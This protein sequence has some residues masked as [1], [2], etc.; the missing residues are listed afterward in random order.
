MHAFVHGLHYGSRMHIIET[1]TERT[2]L[3]LVVMPIVVDAMVQPF[4]DNLPL[5]HDIA[6]VRIYQDSTLDEDTLVERMEDAAAVMV[7]GFHV[8]DSILNRASDHV[9][10]FAFGGTGVGTYI[11][12][13]QTRRLGIRVCNVVHYGNGAVAEHTFALIMELARRVGRMDHTMHE[14]G[15]KGEDGISLEGKTIGLVGFGGIGQSV[16]KISRGF[17]MNVMAWNSH[18]DAFAAADYDATSVNELRDLFAQCD[19]VSLHMPLV[20]ETVGLITSDHLHRMRPGSMLINTARAELIETGAL[21]ARLQRGD[22]MAGLD[23][24]DPEPLPGDDPLRSMPQVVLTPHVAWRTDE[25]YTN[26]TRQVVQS[27]AAFFQGTSYN[28]AN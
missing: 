22:V 4:V 1:Q 28:V 8:S 7:I 25:A 5:L 18:L 19:I 14:G 6:R 26:L 17:G 23:V 21:T 11:N 20:P 9:R 10:C 3:P 16:A 27:V 2:D 24:Y 13:E 12:L 15:W